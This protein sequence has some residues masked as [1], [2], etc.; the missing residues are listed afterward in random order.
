MLPSNSIPRKYLA[1][2]QVHD[3][4]RFSTHISSIATGN[5]IVQI[6]TSLIQNPLILPRTPSDTPFHPSSQNHLLPTPTTFLKPPNANTSPNLP[7]PENNITNRSTPH[8]QPPVGG[9]PHSSA[10]K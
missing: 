5:N 7:R 9:R 3:K 6:P 1:Y 4:V 2:S 8:P 10:C